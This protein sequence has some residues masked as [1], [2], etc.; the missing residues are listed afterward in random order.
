MALL[1]AILPTT[2]LITSYSNSPSR[3]PNPLGGPSR[4]LQGPMQVQYR[5]CPASER[6][7]S[8]W[9]LFSPQIAHRRRDRA[10]HTLSTHGPVICNP[11]TSP[12]TLSMDLTTDIITAATIAAVEC[13]LD[14]PGLPPRPALDPPSEDI[15]AHDAVDTACFT[16]RWR[17]LWALYPPVIFAPVLTNLSPPANVI[18]PPRILHRSNLPAPP[19]VVYA[20]IL[21]PAADCPAAQ[22][23][24]GSN[25]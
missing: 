21:T 9:L 5:I 11:P 2:A 10:S 19:N 24:T 18:P 6:D 23:P 17:C 7:D 22:T 3:S 25:I 13:Q 4:L 12:H 14:N 1:H 15:A 8:Y 20:N 16:P